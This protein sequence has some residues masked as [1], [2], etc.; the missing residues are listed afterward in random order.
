VVSKAAEANL[1]ATDSGKSSTF[2]RMK[3][4]IQREEAI[5]E[6]KRELTGEDV[7][8][9]FAALERNEEIERLLTDIKARKTLPA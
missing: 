9:K 8:A 3:H 5:G 1:Q 4:K 2:D 6:A 7:D